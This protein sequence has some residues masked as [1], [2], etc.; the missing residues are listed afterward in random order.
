MRE[1]REPQFVV[2]GRRSRYRIL[3]PVGSKLQRYSMTLD[4][5]FPVNWF[6]N[7]FLSAGMRKRDEMNTGNNTAS[8]P[9]GQANGTPLPARLLTEIR[10]LIDDTR[11]NIARS[12]NSGL[13][14]LY[15]NNTGR[16]GE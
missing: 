2:L 14:L 8:Q 9:A 7:F 13:V 1:A 6:S 3:E 15:W 11:Q 5:V 12:V 10:G 16:V 4:R